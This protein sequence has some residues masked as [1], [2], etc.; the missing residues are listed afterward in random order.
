MSELKKTLNSNNP[1][2]IRALFAF[3]SKTQNELVAKKFS[4]WAR[5]FFPR[6]FES[7]DAPFH[8]KMDMGNISVYRGFQPEFLNIGYRGCSKTTR[9]KL[10][11]AFAIANDLDKRRKYFKFLSKDQSKANEIVT[12]INNMLIS[13]KA[14]S[15]SPEILERPE[16]TREQTMHSCTT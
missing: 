12:D 8:E 3:D 10:F 7:E 15:D 13:S 16:T 9:T 1:K 2:K 4:Y 11:V 14:K 5:W 6:F